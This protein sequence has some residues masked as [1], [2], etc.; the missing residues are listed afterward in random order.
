M[1]EDHVKL[2]RFED[3]YGM[4]YYVNADLVTHIRAIGESTVIYFGS[5]KHTVTVKM[6]VSEVASALAN[7]GS[8][9]HELEAIGVSARTPK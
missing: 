3:E 7:S 8:L 1:W 4:E 2:V 5:D 9:S 6:S